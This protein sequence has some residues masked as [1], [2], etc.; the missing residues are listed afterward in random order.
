MDNNLQNFPTEE[1]LKKEKSLK[2]ITGILTGFA[3]VLYAAAIS[4]TIKGGIKVTT[5]I[6]CALAISAFLPMQYK[7]I[8]ALRAEINRR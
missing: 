6:I 1:L 4:L 3:I 7:S 5:L 8:K 2:L